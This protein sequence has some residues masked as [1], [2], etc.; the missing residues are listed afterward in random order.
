MAFICFVALALIYF[1]DVDLIHGIYLILHLFLC[2]L[3]IFAAFI[4]PLSWRVHH[5][6]SF[7]LIF[8]VSIYLAFIYL[9][10]IYSF[11]QEVNFFDNKVFNINKLH[12]YKY[13]YE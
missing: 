9:F 7:T 12:I 10:S 11:H 3:F 5:W 4:Y 6:H 13:K 2:H 1:C 8:S